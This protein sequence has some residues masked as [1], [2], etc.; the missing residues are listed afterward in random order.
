MAGYR[1]YQSDLFAAARPNS[2][3]YFIQPNGTWVRG[4]QKSKYEEDY[5][6]LQADLTGKFSTGS[7]EHS[8]LFG[9]DA[10]NLQNRILHL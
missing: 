6:L 8:L 10:E 2:N 4:L 5:C 7:V 1:N 3:S 9:A